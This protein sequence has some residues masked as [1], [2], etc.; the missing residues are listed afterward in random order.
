MILY[1]DASALVK[2][3][4][5]EDGSDLVA[6]AIDHAEA[7]GTAV[8]TG[9]EVGAALAKGARLG[10][11]GEEAARTA[12]RVLR[13]EWPN[14]VR[15][16]ITESVVQSAITLAWEH[17]L[18]GYDSV[19]LAAGLSWRAALQEPICFATFDVSLWNA[20]R[21]AGLEPFPVDLPGVR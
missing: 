19:Q 9:A 12:L 2:R 21:V 4:V 8:I 17:G 10:L 20:A 6:D 16:P 15:L 18:R 14:L 3:Y 5:S 7:A 13:S 11:L 1:L